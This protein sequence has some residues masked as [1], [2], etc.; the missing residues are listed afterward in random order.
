MLIVAVRVPA[1]AGVKVTVMVHELPA[2]NVPLHVEVSAKSP[3]SAPAGGLLLVIVKLPVPVFVT[4]TVCAELVEPM[5]V[6]GKVRLEGL[7]LI[8]PDT[9]VPDSGTVCGLPAALSVTL[10]E[11]ERAP[12]AEGVKVTLIVQVAFGASVPLLPHV[13]V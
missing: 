1:A 12:T 4:V 9:P 2:A 5:G 7:K 8:W 11:A 13:L 3:G 6:L 10:T